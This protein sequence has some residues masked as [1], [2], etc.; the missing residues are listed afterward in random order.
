MFILLYICMYVCVSVCGG[1]V[2]SGS[3][4][5]EYIIICYL[6]LLV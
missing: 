1:G 4:W 2:C 3:E 6:F 5:Y